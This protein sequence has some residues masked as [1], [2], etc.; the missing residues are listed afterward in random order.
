MHFGT[1]IKELIRY[2]Y[3]SIW[4]TNVDSLGHYC[5]LGIQINGVCE[6]PG[7][8][9]NWEGWTFGDWLS[10]GGCLGGEC[11]TFAAYRPTP[12]N[13]VNFCKPIAVKCLTSD[14]LIGIWYVVEVVRIRVI[15]FITINKQSILESIIH[16]IAVIDTATLVVSRYGM[17]VIIISKIDPV[18][19]YRKFVFKHVFSESVRVVVRISEQLL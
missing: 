3:R 17:K 6:C 11:P 19:V 2:F 15:I 10:E 13:N 4:L 18:L 14:H 16:V 9:V 1:W 8:S 12:H 5:M 7:W